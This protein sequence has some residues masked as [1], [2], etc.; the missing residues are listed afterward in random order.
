MRSRYDEPTSLSALALRT[1]LAPEL[2]EI[3]GGVFDP[4]SGCTG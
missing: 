1:A 2:M 4:D 3:I